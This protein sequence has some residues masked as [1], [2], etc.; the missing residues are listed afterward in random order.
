M[1]AIS[2]FVMVVTLFSYPDPWTMPWHLP[3]ASRVPAGHFLPTFGG[4][5]GPP[6]FGGFTFGGFG[7]AGGG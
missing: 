5:G 2:D 1:S 3:F 7:L 4:C 6:A